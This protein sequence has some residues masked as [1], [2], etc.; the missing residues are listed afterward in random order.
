MRR[1]RKGSSARVE[2]LGN[3][4]QELLA[5]Q[6]IHVATGNKYLADIWKKSVGPQIAAQTRPDRLQKGTLYV[7]VASSVWIHQL[8]FLRQEIMDKLNSG[9][10]L[11]N[12]DNIRFFL[13]DISTAQSK[14]EQ[15]F[16][17]S[18]HPLKAKD[19]KNIEKST[20]TVA[21]QELK[22]LLKSVMAKEIIRRRLMEKKGGR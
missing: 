1:R 22:E 12:I 4:L 3:V 11:E 5:G 14:A 8:Q 19:R 9:G 15:K 18:A 7:K 13:A 2:S 16:D 21:D 17:F 10:K 20:E 6:K